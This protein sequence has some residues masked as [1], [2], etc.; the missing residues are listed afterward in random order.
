MTFWQALGRLSVS[1]AHAGTRPKESQNKG[2]QPHLGL[3]LS[4]LGV[5]KNRWTEKRF[6]PKF[7]DPCNLWYQCRRPMSE[8]KQCERLS[9]GVVHVVTPPKEYKNKGLQPH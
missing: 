3:R 1:V 5:L 9:I 8:N 2:L 6:N 7:W 4:F